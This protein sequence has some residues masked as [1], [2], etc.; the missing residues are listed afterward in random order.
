MILALAAVALGAIDA[1][2]EPLPGPVPVQ[3]IEVVDG[4]TIRV[5]AQVWLD[6]TLTISVRLRGVDTPESRSRCPAEREA[7]ARAK[8]WVEARM[9]GG[10]LTLE[11]VDHDKYARRAVAR[12]R[13]G[14]GTD[15]ASGLIK[16]GLARPYDGGHKATWCDESGSLRE[17]A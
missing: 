7:A 8:A 5:A 2:A 17:G 10:G 3:V 16:A 12:V 6:Q 11:Q 14:D 4:D 9:A 13:L 1:A 15:L